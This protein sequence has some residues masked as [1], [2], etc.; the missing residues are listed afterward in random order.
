MLKG[1]VHARYPDAFIACLKEGFIKWSLKAV[2]E[3][4][5]VSILDRDTSFSSRA[6][7]RR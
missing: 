7:G 6:C 1:D 5:I 3:Q 2:S 4:L